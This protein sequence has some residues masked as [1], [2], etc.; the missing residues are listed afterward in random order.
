[1]GWGRPRCYPSNSL[2]CDLQRVFFRFCGFWSG[3]IEHLH[4]FSSSCPLKSFQIVRFGGGPLG[5]FSDLTSCRAVSSSN[6]RCCFLML[7]RMNHSCFPNVVYMSDKK[8]P[9]CT[10]SKPKRSRYVS[11]LVMS[12]SCPKDFKDD[13]PKRTWLIFEFRSSFRLNLCLN[14]WLFECF[15]GRSASDPSLLSSLMHSQKANSKNQCR[16]QISSISGFSELYRR[17]TT[18]YH[19][20][21]GQ[22][23][24]LK[25]PFLRAKGSSV[26]GP[27]PP[28]QFRALRPIQRGEELLHSYLGREFLAS[29]WELGRVK[30]Q[31]TLRWFHNGFKRVCTWDIME[32]LFSGPWNFGETHLDR[33]SPTL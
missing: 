6:L 14:F 28:R 29:T 32:P 10:W 25:W 3:A 19:Q 15:I 12:E 33:N 21:S 13:I 1:M 5:H 22:T 20:K 26:Q 16:L 30:N 17:V 24:P 8:Q 18:C 7:S 31:S 23:M 27:G 2:W 9:D 11:F 4:T